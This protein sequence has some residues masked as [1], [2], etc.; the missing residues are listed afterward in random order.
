MLHMSISA[1]SLLLLQ[2]HQ[3]APADAFYSHID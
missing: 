1:S 3:L 2:V